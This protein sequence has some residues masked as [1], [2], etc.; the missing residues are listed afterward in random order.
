MAKDYGWTGLLRHGLWSCCKCKHWNYY[1]TVTLRIDSNCNS[2]GCDYRARIVLDRSERKGGRP[3]QCIVKEYP[4]YR[5]PGTVKSEQRERNRH[6]RR[7]RE[8]FERMEIK[9]DRGVFMTGTDLQEAQD[10]ADLKRHGGVFRLKGRPEWKRHPHTGG[11]R[12]ELIRDELFI[13]GLKETWA[14]NSESEPQE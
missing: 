12:V 3:R 6:S 13:L 8:L 1:R 5:P 7:E 9:T 2:Q 10:K 14:K 4:A 11:S